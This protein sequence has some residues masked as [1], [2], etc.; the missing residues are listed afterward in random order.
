MKE[1]RQVGGLDVRHAATYI[2]M[3][4]LILAGC[5]SRQRI[6]IPLSAPLPHPQLAKMQSISPEEKEG[7]IYFGNSK[8]YQKRGITIVLLKGNP[9][10]IGYS[11][12]VLLKDEIRTW[13]RDSLYMIRKFSL[14]MAIGEELMT[15]RTR[16]VEKFIPQEYREELTGLSAGSGVDYQTLLMLNVLETIGRQFMGCTSIAVI[17]ADGHLLR[18]RNLDYR[19]LEYL[20]PWILIVYQPIHGYALASISAPGSIGVSTA[21]NE[22]GITFGNHEI[23]RSSR[24]WKGIPADILHR[25]VIQ[26]AGSI[27]DAGKIL[28]QSPRCLPE[29]WLVTDK[30]KACIY[31]FNDRKMGIKDMDG[32]FLILTNFTRV[33]NIGINSSNSLARYSTAKSFLTRHKNKMNLKRLIELNRDGLLSWVPSQWGFFN[34]YSVIIAPST[35]DFWIAIDPP[36]ATRGRWIGFNLVKELYGTGAEPKPPIIPAMD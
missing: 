12:G 31:E 24:P 14:S 15:K 11:R 17:G 1:S 9:Y 25:Q 23:S 33:L 18:S 26:Y 32:D 22:K 34:L 20:L 10:E 7:I 6:Q 28:A 13:V 35:H 3:A 8:R 30:E 19:D 27:K 29:M 2:F 21:I 5:V 36:P 4:F 16:D